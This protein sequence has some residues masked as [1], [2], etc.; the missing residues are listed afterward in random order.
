MGTGLI[1]ELTA[2]LTGQHLLSESPT[3]PSGARGRPTTALTAHPD[4]PL[5]L[6]VVIAHEGWRVTAVELGGRT[7]G[8]TAGSNHRSARSTLR[9]I[10]AAITANQE[11]FPDRIRAIAVSVPGTVGG[12]RVLQAPGLEWHGVELNQLC[13][14]ASCALPLLAGNDASFAALAEARRGAAA[15]ARTSL[16]LFIEAGLGGAVVDAGGVVGGANGLA[17]EFGHLPFGD[18]SR[19]CVCGAFGC[20]NT[21]L[22]AHSLARL[23]GEPDP[24]HAH[25]VTY[26]RGVLAAA[27]AGVVPAIDAVEQVSA[28]LGRGVAGLVNALDPEVVILGGFARDLLELGS[29]PLHDAYVAGLMSFRRG[30]P[31][32][33]IPARFDELAPGIG[34]AEQCFDLLLDDDQLSA[35]VMR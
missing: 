19:R 31:P 18:R 30:D 7:L 35:W 5:A 4:G 29:R 24:K 32:S 34:A 12:T 23:R 33:L 17:G 26:V 9:A 22:D 2:R 27:S 11:A 1:A 28:E 16:Y 20:W 21:S 13:A 8:E 14:G 15:T 25:E 3:A 10:A 6:A